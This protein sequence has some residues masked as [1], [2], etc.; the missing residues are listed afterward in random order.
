MKRLRATIVINA[1]LITMSINSQ[2]PNIW[3]LSKKTN[4][5]I[6]LISILP[7]HIVACRGDYH[8]AFGFDDWIVC[9]YVCMYKGWAFTAL[10]PRPRVVY[11]A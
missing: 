9:M 11:C 6:A 3:K 4:H 10:A 2:K 7:K 5:F 8:T 1:V